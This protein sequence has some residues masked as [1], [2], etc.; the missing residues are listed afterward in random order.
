MDAIPSLDSLRALRPL[1]ARGG[2][3][4]PHGHA[5]A[6]PH[7]ARPARR[8]R[9]AGL[10]TAGFVSGY[11]GS[12]LGGVDLELW[13]AKKLLEASAAS[14]SSPP[15]TK[16]SPPP[17]CSARSRSRP[18]RRARSMAC[19][20]SGTARAPASIA[21]A[22]RSSTA[23]PMAPRRMAACWS[24]PATTMAACRP[25]CRTS[26]TSP[27]WLVHADA[28]PRK[29]QRISRIRRI[30]LRAEPLLRH[31]GRLQG[32]LGNRRVRRIRRAARRAAS[33]TRPTSHRRRAACTIAGP[34]CPARRSRS[35]WKP[36]STR[37]CAFATANPI[38]RQIY[39]IP[40][41]HLRH[42]HHGQ[43]ASRPDGSAAADGPR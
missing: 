15:S 11:R 37:C 24:S 7:P 27:S 41:R 2:P 6:R 22:T 30:W 31:V 32:D 36:R 18:G 10:N 43:G 1:R 34:T 26:P 9:A 19:S 17:R 28:A 42:R 25:R 3:R 20:A 39:D 14:N 5:G 23:T 29:R 38:D 35:G 21:P 40:E 8:D 33:S 12:P 16:T 4:L 13:R